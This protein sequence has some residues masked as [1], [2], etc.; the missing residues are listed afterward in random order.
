MNIKNT[1][2]VCVVILFSLQLSA[3]VAGGSNEKLAKL[4]NT[5][6][7]ESCLYKADSYTYKENHTND[8]EPYLYISMCLYELSKSDDPE[9]QEDYKDAIKQ[10]IKYV[11]KFAKKDK[12]NEY[13]PLNIEYVNTIKKI[14]KTNV[15]SVKA[16]TQTF[17]LK[18]CK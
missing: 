14:Q 12:H 9:I 1:L 17:D 15:K 8:P 4:Y 18:H 13:Y 16:M 3:Q 10:A 5:G 6:K 11:G 7:Y 2:F